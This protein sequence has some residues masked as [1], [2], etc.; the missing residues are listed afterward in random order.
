MLH[1]LEHLLTHERVLYF[2]T[3]SYNCV[4]NNDGDI[5][6]HFLNAFD[7][8]VCDNN[9]NLKST[10]SLE[11]SFLCASVTNQNE[12]LMRKGNKVFVY[13]KEGKLKRTINVKNEICAVTFNYDT[14]NLEIMEETTLIGTRWSFCIRSYSENDEVECLYVPINERHWCKEYCSHPTGPAA[15][16]YRR[17]EFEKKIILVVPYNF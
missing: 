10:L 1:F 11:K 4:I 17:S 2:L 16:V 15:L 6:I 7:L 8:Y 9:G 14:S 3:M 5:I 13:T 12:I